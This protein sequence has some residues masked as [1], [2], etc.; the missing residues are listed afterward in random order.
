MLLEVE[1]LRMYYEIL[2]KGH[3]KAVDGVSFSLDRGETLGIVGESGCGKSSLAITILRILPINAKIYSG[4]ILLDGVDILKMD[5]EKFRREIRW[6]RISMV[7]QGAMNALNPVI[8]VGDQIAEAIMIHKRVSKKTAMRRVRELLE[9]VGIDPSRA[10]SYPFEFSGG[11][12]QRA[13]IAMAL[14][15]NP[16]IVIADEPTTALDVIVQAQILKLIKDI[17]RRFKLSVILISHDISM[18]SELSDK[19][20]IM[21]AGQIVEY[22]DIVEIFTNPLHPYTRALLSSVPSI[23]GKRRKLHSIAGAPPNLLRPPP[24]CRF[25]PR[26]PFRIEICSREEPEFMM[27]SPNHFVKCH[28]FEELRGVAFGSASS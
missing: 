11:M 24:G 15:L 16:D 19:I 21:Y 4:R 12:R 6:R 25:H 26:C 20:A 9:M 14:A 18:V 1:N 22:G 28:R 27:V 5:L 17:Q 7:F 8:K 3:V 23:K 10:N 13:M 2:G